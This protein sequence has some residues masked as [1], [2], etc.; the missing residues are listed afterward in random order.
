[1]Y[2]LSKTYIH[3]HGPSYA[4]ALK[5]RSLILVTLLG[6]HSLS[7]TMAASVFIKLSDG[8]KLG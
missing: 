1:V 6:L 5:L 7:S 3:V 4:S 8:V 2:T